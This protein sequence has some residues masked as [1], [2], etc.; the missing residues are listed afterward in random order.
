MSELKD[1]VVV[2]YESVL[3]N[4]AAGSS[5]YWP[6]L[7][8]MVLVAYCVYLRRTPRDQRGISGFL[9]Y[10]VPARMYLHRSTRLDAVCLLINSTLG[11]TIMAPLIASLGVGYYCMAETTGLLNTLFGEFGA[12]WD[13]TIGIQVVLTIALMLMTDFSFYLAHRLMHRVGFL[14]EFHK[15]HH[16]AEVMTPVTASR[17]H[18]VE[19]ILTALFGGIAV[20]MTYGTFDYLTTAPVEQLEYLGTNIIV[21]G[22]QLLVQNLQHSHIWLDFGRIGNRI[23]ISPAHHQVHH[24][25][26]RRHVDTNY[27]RIFALWDT[28]FNSLYA[29]DRYEALD[30]GLIHK[31]EQ[32]ELDGVW[33]LYLV[34][35]GNLFKRIQ[36]AVLRLLPSAG[37]LPVVQKR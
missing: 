33:R 16:S 14:W 31:E 24:S 19:A 13:P 36:R 15:V 23:L 17:T 3:E 7:V 9:R 34:P 32:E 28:L 20:G 25:N 21:F 27:G 5:F 8:G 22:F 6:C 37:T 18:P 26:A 30:Y 35:F 10:V 2:A 1:I 29:P 11:G 12:R 4:F